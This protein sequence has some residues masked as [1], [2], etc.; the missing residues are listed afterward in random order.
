MGFH[1]HLS[2]TD[3]LVFVFVFVF[4]SGKGQEPLSVRLI[5]TNGDS[6]PTSHHHHHDPS[7]NQQD[8]N[9]DC[10]VSP[11]WGLP[12]PTSPFTTAETAKGAAWHTHHFSILP[13]SMVLWI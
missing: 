2:Y 1:Y 3:T 13:L 4:F 9:Q 12:A 6:I 5:A 10:G 11:S 8:P 7:S